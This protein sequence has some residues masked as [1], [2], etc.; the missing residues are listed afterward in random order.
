M[1]ACNE[2][3]AFGIATDVDDDQAHRQTACG[4]GDKWYR[5]GSSI[6]Q[7]V[8]QGAADALSLVRRGRSSCDASHLDL[9]PLCPPGQ[10]G[11][12]QVQPKCRDES[13]RKAFIDLARR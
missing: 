6:M 10:A 9:V 8:R 7:A 4:V 1:R 13:I 3:P 2:F 5:V 12:N 11:I